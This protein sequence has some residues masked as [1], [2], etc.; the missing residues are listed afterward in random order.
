MLR[1]CCTS[2]A[3]SAAAAL[4][5]ATAVSTLSSSTRLAGASASGCSWITGSFDLLHL[6]IE[7]SSAL[8]KLLGAC[9]SSIAMPAG[10]S[11]KRFRLSC[12]ADLP[13]KWIE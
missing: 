9:C 11:S 12:R 4:S 8:A 5:A 10:S 2:A 3:A 1:G 7:L 13:E 6:A